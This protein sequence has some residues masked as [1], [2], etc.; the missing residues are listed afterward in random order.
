MS[1]PHFP[2]PP[3]HTDRP[4]HLLGSDG[5]PL[6]NADDVHLILPENVRD[7][8][9]VHLVNRT[10]TPLREQGIV[11][12][13]AQQQERDAL[14]QLLESGTVPEDVAQRIAQGK[15]TLSAARKA[16]EVLR[17][18]I[19][20]IES[21]P[22]HIPRERLFTDQMEDMFRSILSSLDKGS[23]EFKAIQFFLEKFSAVTHETVDAHKDREE[24]LK[25]LATALKPFYLP[26]NVADRLVRFLFDHTDPA[27]DDRAALRPSLRQR[28]M[29][30]RMLYHLHTYLQWYDFTQWKDA[31]VRNFFLPDPALRTRYGHLLL[32]KYA[33][34]LTDGDRERM[35]RFLAQQG[36]CATDIAQRLLTA[37]P[38]V[39]ETLGDT[40]ENLTDY[41]TKQPLPADV[42]SIT[43]RREIKRARNEA[44]PYR[45]IPT[46]VGIE[47]E[48]KMA[49]EDQIQSDELR[50]VLRK[51]ED[52]LYVNRGLLWQDQDVAEIAIG[53]E[54]GLPLTRELLQKIRALTA[55]IEQLPAF[56]SWATNHIHVDA[57][58]GVT[59]NNSLF[60]FNN[61]DEDD[62]GFETK[63]V[64]YA[65]NPDAPYIFDTQ[66]ISDQMIVLG[67]LYGKTINT[68]S[69]E[70]C[71][72]FFGD[73]ARYGSEQE[74][75][76]RALLVASK[77]D[78]AVVPAL[79][80]L[81]ERKKLPLLNLA[82]LAERV[83][84][85]QSS[86]TLMRL[87]A[88][89]G[90]WDGQKAIFDKIPKAERTH[91]VGA[92]LSDES[93][94]LH[95]RLIVHVLAFPNKP[96]PGDPV[97]VM[98]AIAEIDNYEIQET[99]AENINSL[100]GT[101]DVIRAIAE[102]DDYNL[103]L[104]L[105]DK[106][107]SLPGTVEIVRAIAEVDDYNARY[108]LID[109]ITS[110]PGTVDVIRA[111]AE[112]DDYSLQ[113]N[114]IDK[115]TSLPGTVE[116]V[117]AI[118]EV[119]SYELQEILAQNVE[120]LPGTVAIMA[121]IAEIYD[122]E[123]QEILVSKIP[124][125]ER[126]EAAAMFFND[127]QY[128]LVERL[129]IHMLVF[130][131][132]QLSGNPV[133]IISIIADEEVD[134]EL[135]E[136]IAQKVDTLPGTVEVVRMI[137]KINNESIQ[138]ILIT[139]I[140][141]LHGTAE[142]IQALADITYWQS[143]ELLVE[144][145]HSVSGTADTLRA[146]AQISSILQEILV[147][148]IATLSPTTETIS[149]ITYLSYSAQKIIF[150]KI[151]SQ[152]FIAAAKEFV[153]NDNNPLYE[154]LVVQHFVFPER[155]IEGTKENIQA[156]MEVDNYFIRHNLAEKITKT[157]DL[158]EIVRESESSLDAT[159]RLILKNRIH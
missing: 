7:H 53:G 142:I 44:D 57:R 159:T 104:D 110:L 116:I 139:K 8:D 152:E 145:I 70:M 107:T 125:T 48:F 87:I 47:L 13:T 36:E 25:D 6:D 16:Q 141:N 106:I 55:E 30:H 148:K 46:K 45:E 105:I 62:K 134:S 56:V 82:A 137:A 114:L 120:P 67:R 113:L 60:A 68:L 20:A 143:T 123:A 73:L 89:M 37:Y 156:L 146:I 144:K 71:T 86:I 103:Q 49:G 90:D 132:E 17:E 43:L 130:P 10:G 1:E 117:R 33:D 54:H 135:G 150:D 131:E 78:P 140:E 42:D 79:L 96:L 149:S 27:K 133:E 12:T 2:Q 58:K 102:I 40:T 83:D 61:Y 121:A 24:S 63:N 101:V 41:Y 72:Q 28:E 111:I 85:V 50:N 75:T 80:R 157:H 23:E 151:A 122:Y 19:D 128:P 84:A 81:A 52:I 119:D 76:L 74:A 51:Y 21:N 129:I 77:D 11:T 65:Y 154:R 69:P 92:F 15:M 32:T 147:D 99:L 29:L 31:M 18:R 127:T 22:G 153:D 35:M 100:P 34:A 66:T 158:Q 97:D 9:H 39:R 98:R 118:A 59:Y 109:K 4:P 95:E 14:V 155:T 5:K 93:I 124:E 64:P 94:P 3:S 108:I 126:E 112:I 88:R 138:R 38:Q 136:S 26:Q 115:I 91:I